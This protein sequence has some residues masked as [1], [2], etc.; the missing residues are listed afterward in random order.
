MYLV[1]RVNGVDI[2]SIFRD[3]LN[4]NSI[5][6]DVIL[7][8]TFTLP[9]DILEVIRTFSRPRMRFFSEFNKAV[10]FLDHRS[11]YNTQF[12]YLLVRDVKKKL[13]TSEAEKYILLFVEYVAATLN[14]NA[15]INAF[16]QKFH[17]YEF[18]C[19][20][21]TLVFRTEPRKLRR[22]LFVLLYT[23]EMVQAYDEALEAHD[24]ALT[25]DE[26]DDDD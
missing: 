9:D 26:D 20:S 4:R 24:E 6:H 22:E 7:N 5:E 10:R 3:K 13:F 25:M 2:I 15:K 18:V 8:M 16:V 19:H 21:D 1:M 11:H 14:C 23:K 12:N 17:W